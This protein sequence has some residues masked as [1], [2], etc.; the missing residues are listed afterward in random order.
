M[1]P[2]G[3][4]AAGLLVLAAAG[5]G[6]EPEP[7]TAG[8]SG[9]AESGVVE[10]V[11]DGDTLRLRDGRRVRLVQ[12]D[13]PELHGDCYGK[14]A[15]G[16]LRRLAPEGAR[17][18]LERDPRLDARDGYGRLLRYV[19]A[20]GHNL[21]MTLVR[22]GAASPYFFRSERG[23]YAQALLGAVDEARRERRGYWGACPGAKLNTG[24]GSLTGP[25]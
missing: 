24:L 16:A 5:C 11:N 22:Q 15:L 18:T 19:F 21:N 10:Y 12:I 13:A 14:A 9:P 4:A 7:G 8:A 3:A 6:G 23:R 25:A 2:A 20:S 17:V 1:R